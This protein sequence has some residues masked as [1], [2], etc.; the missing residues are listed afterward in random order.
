MAMVRITPLEVQVRCD[1]LDGRPRS[2]RLAGERLPVVSVER[3]RSE[4]SAHP[5]LTGPRTLFEVE[6]PGARLA[7]TFDHRSRRW[8]VEGLDPLAGADRPA[9]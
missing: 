3:I 6:T 5:A 7:L 1:W 8:R 2:I 4:A 9:A